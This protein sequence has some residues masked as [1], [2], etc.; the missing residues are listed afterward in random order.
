MFVVRANGKLR[1]VCGGQEFTPDEAGWI[2]WDDKLQPEPSDCEQGF[3]FF[4]DWTRAHQ[5]HTEWVQQ[6]TSGATILLPILY[7]G[8]L[9]SFKT[10]EMFTTP[11]VRIEVC[12]RFKVVE[13]GW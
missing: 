2:T 5:A 8:G 13:R 7:E 10:S 1:P 11:I 6:T 12:R 9:G 4:V 3:C